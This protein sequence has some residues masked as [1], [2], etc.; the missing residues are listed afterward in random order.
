M[1]TLA[2]LVFTSWYLGPDGFHLGIPSNCTDHTTSVHGV[3][4]SFCTKVWVTSTLPPLLFL[5][6]SVEMF[7]KAY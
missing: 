3:P 5:R 2:G 1:L 6:L 7:S 4:I